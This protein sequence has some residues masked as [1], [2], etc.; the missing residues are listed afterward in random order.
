M[1]SLLLVFILCQIEKIISSIFVIGF[2]YW[3]FGLNNKS[4]IDKSKILVE[5][6]VISMSFKCFHNECKMLNI[7]KINKKFIAYF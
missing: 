4:F 6:T 7:N 2:F 5:K 1:D 3:I